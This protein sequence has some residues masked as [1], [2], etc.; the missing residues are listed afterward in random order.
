MRVGFL[1]GSFNPPHCGHLAL[2]RT[3]LD[4]GLVDSVMLVPAAV[5]PHK[6]IVGNVSSNLRLA[7]TR[8]L[9]EED[10]RVLVCDIELR[11]T[12]KSYTIDTIHELYDEHPEWR[13]RLILGSDMA[14]SFVTWKEY[15]E[16]LRIA[17]PLVAE[18]PDAPFSADIKERYQGLTE[19]DIAV[20]EEGR[21]AMTP[22]DISSTKIRAMVADGAGMEELS[23]VL[24]PGVARFVME[25]RLYSS[26]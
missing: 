16:L 12:G 18:R 19:E 1:G 24:T 13:L 11:R 7:M 23:P 2:A 21:F 3:V 8:V 15:R 5:P 26:E 10:S 6:T 9:A 25:H 22:V 20:L 14:K 4:L 17:P